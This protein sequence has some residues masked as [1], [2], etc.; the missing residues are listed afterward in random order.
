MRTLIYTILMILFG[1]LLFAQEKNPF[2]IDVAP[3][4]VSV[5]YVKSIHKKI[6]VGGGLGTGFNFF[7]YKSLFENSIAHMGVEF[8]H[9]SAF[10][11]Y[12]L[13]EKVD[14]TLGPRLTGSFF[15]QPTIYGAQATLSIGGFFEAMYGNDKVKGGIRLIIAKR[16]NDTFS[17]FLFT[18]AVFRFS[19]NRD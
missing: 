1:Q 17:D 15:Y 6:D 19:L 7:I 14:V 11:R 16:L 13:S 10:G 8:F 5:Y 9:A 4:G 3:V 18:P 12:S 2:V